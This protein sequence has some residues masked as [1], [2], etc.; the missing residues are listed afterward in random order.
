[1]KIR[2]P[3]EP[4]ISYGTILTDLKAKIGSK[5]YL[6]CFSGFWYH[7]HKVSVDYPHA[8]APLDIEKFPTLKVEVE[9]GDTTL[10]FTT[11]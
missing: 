9:M 3:N 8:V 11:Q 7:G 10:I 1:M 4:Y 6:N 2:L 5:D